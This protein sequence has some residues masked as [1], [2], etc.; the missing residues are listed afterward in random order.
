MHPDSVES[1]GKLKKTKVPAG[2][3]QTMEVECVDLTDESVPEDN[4]NSLASQS[5]DAGSLDE[6][7][8]ACGKAEANSNVSEGPPEVEIDEQASTPRPPRSKVQHKVFKTP[9]KGTSNNSMNSGEAPKRQSGS[10][11]PSK[12][13]QIIQASKEKRQS[14]SANSTVD[15]YAPNKQET[16]NSFFKSAPAGVSKIP[17]GELGFL[18]NNDEDWDYDGTSHFKRRCRDQMQLEGFMENSQNLINIDVLT[19]RVKFIAVKADLESLTKSALKDLGEGLIEVFHDIL[20]ELIQIS[21]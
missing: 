3:K 6:N 20:A 15:K 14:M 10:S 11:S 5:V 1:I 8:G 2:N 21:R 13:A 9:S 17:D 4:K 7:A 18:D 19:E 16:L 12:L